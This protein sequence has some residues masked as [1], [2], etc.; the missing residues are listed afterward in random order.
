MGTEENKAVGR[1]F[2]E[3]VAS[4]RDVSVAED[5]VAPNYV[6]LAIPGVDVAGLKAMTSAMHAAIG[7]ARIGPLEL[8]AEG[9]AVFARF[10]YGVTL[11]DGSEYT[12]R[13]LS[14]YHLTDGRI[15]VNDVMMV[16]DMLEVLGP[17]SGPPPTD[18]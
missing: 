4:G 12:A 1:R 6:N 7:E 8:V 14:Y 13:N 16:P 15:D 10:D 17:L 9:D 18:D 2:I 5:I 3:D 11:P